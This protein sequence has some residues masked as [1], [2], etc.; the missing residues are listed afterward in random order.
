MVEWLF[1]CSVYFFFAWYLFKFCCKESA[2]QSRRHRRHGFDS[3]VIPG[4]GRSPGGGNN[5]PFLYSCLGNFC[6]R[7]AWRDSPWNCKEWDTTEWL[8]HTC[9]LDIYKFRKVICFWF[10]FFINMQMFL[11]EVRCGL[12]LT[13]W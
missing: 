6:D 4:S 13:T 10:K 9:I 5:N 11:L 8:R 1:C 2:Y 3:W 12:S 7:G